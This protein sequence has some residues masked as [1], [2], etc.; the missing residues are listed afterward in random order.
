MKQVDLDVI[1]RSTDFLTWYFL[2]EG[3]AI[4]NQRYDNLHYLNHVLDQRD[5]G[6]EILIFILIQLG[7]I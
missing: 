4:S 5:C 2:T 6:V 3:S 7:L 1:V